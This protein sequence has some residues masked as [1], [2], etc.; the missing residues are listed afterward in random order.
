MEQRDN[1]TVKVRVGRGGG[2]LITRVLFRR[3]EVNLRGATKC[4]RAGIF[5]WPGEIECWWYHSAEVDEIFF[6]TTSCAIKF[7]H[8][9]FKIKLRVSIALGTVSETTNSIPE[10]KIKIRLETLTRKSNGVKRRIRISSGTHGP[11]PAAYFFSCP[12]DRASNNFSTRFGTKCSFLSSR[13]R[14]TRAC[15]CL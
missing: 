7:R 12:T 1:E 6:H 13:R 15:V 4:V 5:L 10:S 9:I 8:I 11:L 14:R 2:R 3:V